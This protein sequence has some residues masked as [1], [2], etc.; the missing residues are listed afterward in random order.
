MLIC[1]KKGASC[2]VGFLNVIGQINRYKSAFIWDQTLWRWYHVASAWI[3]LTLEPVDS[4][5]AYRQIKGDS[6]SAWSLQS[7]SSHL[8][9]PY[10][11]LLFMSID[12]FSSSLSKLLL[13]THGWLGMNSVTNLTST[14]TVLTLW[15]PFPSRGNLQTQPEPRDGRVKLTSS[16]SPPSS[17]SRYSCLDTYVSQG[18]EIFLTKKN[19]GAYRRATQNSLHTI[20]NLYIRLRTWGRIT[21]RLAR[22]VIKVCVR[23]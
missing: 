8:T 17:S 19:G 1:W 22:S 18:R 13:E 10:S 11:K 12:G 3:S 9:C 7:S 15:N 4:S 6:R 23:S 21:R 5:S 16:P 14:R 20:W 2:L